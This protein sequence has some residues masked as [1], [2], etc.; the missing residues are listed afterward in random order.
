MSPVNTDRVWLKDT[1][2]QLSGKIL[3]IE[4]LMVLGD[5]GCWVQ[6]SFNCLLLIDV[7]L[8]R[9][10]NFIMTLTNPSSGSKIGPVPAAFI[11]LHTTGKGNHASLHKFLSFS[12]NLPSCEQLF[13]WIWS[14]QLPLSNWYYSCLW[15]TPIAGSRF[16]PQSKLNPPV[17]VSFGS[18]IT[19][20]WMWYTH[21]FYCS[22][23]Q[24]IWFLFWSFF[25]SQL[26]FLCFFFI[27]R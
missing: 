9:H 1:F 17:H 12:G 26:G 8:Q 4:N 22:M 14:S 23:L 15:R 20:I 25:S 5:A 3:G 19:K 16:G 11:N 7:I 2:V 21:L 18:G 13:S 6:T 24:C 27:H 10:K